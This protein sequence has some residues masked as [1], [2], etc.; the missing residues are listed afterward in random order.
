MTGA[1][2]SS[3]L[4]R[5][6]WPI[7][8][9]GEC[10]V[11]TP[12][13]GINAPAVP[14][15]HDLPT[16]IRITDIDDAGRFVPAPKVSVSDPSASDYYLEYGDI[17]LART[18]ASVGKSYLHR[19]QDGRLVYAGFL[20]Q[21]RVDDRK[22]DPEFLSQYLR[23]KPYWDWVEGMSLRSGQ[24]GIN[25]REYAS[26]PVPLP[27]LSEQRRIAGALRDVD[28]LNES[29]E[30]LI[31]K[32]LMVKAA[33]LRR[34]FAGQ[35][36]LTRPRSEWTRYRLDQLG[37]WMKGRGI[38]KD[39]VASAGVPCVRY[40]ELYTKYRSYTASLNNYVP[41]DVADTA[42]P[43]Q[44]GDLLFTSSGETADEIG[45]CL[46]YV[47]S[48]PAVAGGDLVVLRPSSG[49]HNPVFLSH[50]LNTPAVAAEKARLGQ[51]DA[52][53][54]I[55]ARALGSLEVN[56]PTREE[57][58]SVAEVLTDMDSEINALER[59]LAKTRDVKRG[60]MQE[61]LTGRTR[62]PAEEAAA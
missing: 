43:I 33:A 52:V 37:Q 6:P 51:G 20:I 50:L 61:L 11:S 58:D 60:M 30:R 41:Q 19:P 46:A 48:G 35:S 12:S 1:A 62:L 14:Y 36:N 18:G 4:E 29:L 45:T 56:L 24:P 16:Y 34:L 5:C 38:R 59:R 10:L 55:N 53:V 3:T 27:Q 22:L 15:R 40:G 8:E 28:E 25:S 44:R 54:H 23:S 9:L 39:D 57:Q 2:V 26:L 21:V 17:L 49:D 7:V 42:L 32:H 47:G 13:Y 31:D